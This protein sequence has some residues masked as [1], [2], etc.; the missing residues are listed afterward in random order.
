MDKRGISHVEV[1]LSFLIFIGFVIFALYFFNPGNTSRVVG[2]S[3]DYIF[4]EIEDE[5]FVA[6][7]SYSIS[8]NDIGR[9]LG[10]SITVEVKTKLSGWNVR[11]ENWR[12]DAIPSRR[13][14]DLVHFR[15][16]G[17]VYGGGKGFVVVK[18]SED[19]E[20]YSGAVGGS[21]HDETIYEI[22]SSNTDR[23][24]SEKRFK[25]LKSR[26]ET[27]YINLKEEFNLPGRVEFGFRLRFDD[28]SE[29][30]AENEIPNGVDVFSELKRVEVLRENGEIKFADLFVKIW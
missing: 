21:L 22:A 23:V 4:S 7:E 13:E 18:I 17:V 29:I 14:G 12:G 25:D 5:V 26:Y 30:I 1:L 28:G 15:K 27:D 16:S 8:I 11:V 6:V 20:P 2:S 9:A 10:D 24:V 3:M 19:Y